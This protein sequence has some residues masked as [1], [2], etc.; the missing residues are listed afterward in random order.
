LGHVVVEAEDDDDDDD[1]FYLRGRKLSSGRCWRSISRLQDKATTMVKTTKQVRTIKK[2]IRLDVQPA[3]E[4]P[5]ENDALT[6]Y[7]TQM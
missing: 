2:G 3:E 4:V 1:G 7:R 6:G 5:K